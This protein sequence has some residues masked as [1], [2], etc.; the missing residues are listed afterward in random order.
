M[1]L[2][3]VLVCSAMQ[4][5]MHMFPDWKL[6]LHILQKMLDVCWKQQSGIQILLCS[7]EMNFC[8]KYLSVLNYIL[9]VHVFCHPSANPIH[10]TMPKH[11]IE[12]NYPISLCKHLSL[13]DQ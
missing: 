10:S 2:L 6:W 1:E 7:S 11:A 13:T 4:L 3:T 5:G 8:M 9:Y 12:K